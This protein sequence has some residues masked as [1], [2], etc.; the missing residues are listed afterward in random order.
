MNLTNMEHPSLLK[1]TKTYQEIYPVE[2]QLT[3]K[4][5]A[6][7]PL[8]INDVSLFIEMFTD[9]QVMK[10]AGGTTP[11]EK[12]IEE[13]QM[14]TRRGGSGCIGVWCICDR[15]TGESLGSTSLTPLPI[16]KDDTDWEQLIEDQLPDGE[17]EIGYFLNRA[18][19]GNGYATEAADRILQFA[20][21]DS[22]IEE[23][24]AVIHPEN[25]GS[26]K[27]L[28]K[29]GFSNTGFRRAYGE[30]LS[31]FRILRGDWLDRQ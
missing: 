31:G 24:V 22:P 18:T 15:I 4:R 7:R 5:L 16:D 10:Y 1:L 11:E 9:V 21:E 17:V 3:T 23:V 6:L 13:M 19:W 27:V 28:E 26:K 29:I 14:W 8:S 2:L 12:I 30:D 25:C 20:F